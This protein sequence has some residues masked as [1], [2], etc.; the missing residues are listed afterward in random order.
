MPPTIPS[1]AT[2]KAGFHG[3]Y[4]CYGYHHL[5]VICGRH[6]LAAEL[7]RSNIDASA[8]ASMRSNASRPRS[9]AGQ[10]GDPL[11]AYS[12][13]A[14]DESMSWREAKASITLR[15]RPQ[16]PSGR[17]DHRRLAAAAAESPA[18]GSG[19]SLRRSC[20][21]TLNSWSCERRVVAKAEHLPQCQF[22]RFV[23]TSLPAGEILART[24]YEELYPARG[25]ME[26]RIK[27]QSSTCSPIAHQR[28]DPRQSARLWFASFAR[29]RGAPSA[30]P[31]PVRQRHRWHDPPEALE[32]RRPGPDH[33]RRSSSPWPRRPYR[34]EH[35]SLTGT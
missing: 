33:V 3:Y 12:G 18:L 13:F 24:L 14:R 6:L 15:P 9:G 2:R 20:L 5:Y 23:V 7:R 17:R 4:D 11:R 10:G 31:Q 32:D 28:R 34:N 29:R 16:R 1:T 27:E 30:S 19:P 25:E 22:P 35:H 26:N 8:G 21:A